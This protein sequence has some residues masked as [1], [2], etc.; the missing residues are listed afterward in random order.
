VKQRH[1]KQRQ[2][3]NDKFCVL[4]D[5]QFVPMKIANRRKVGLKL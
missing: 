3:E 2:A 4:R 5:D 1:A